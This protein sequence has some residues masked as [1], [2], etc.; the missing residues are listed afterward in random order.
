MIMRR[1][2]GFS[3]IELLVSVALVALLLALLLPGL[4]MARAQARAVKCASN[5]RQLAQAFHMYGGEYRGRAMPLAYTAPKI[6]GDGPPVYWWGTNG[7]AGVD[8]TRGFVWPYLHADLRQNGVFECPDQPWGT[9]RP[10]GAARQVTSTYGYNGYYLCPPHTPGWSAPGPGYIGDR[11]W[12]NIDTLPAPQRLFVF[13]DTLIDLGTGRAENNALLDP[14]YLWFRRRWVANSS[15]TTCFRHAHEA[16][17][18][19]GDGH[20]ERFDPAGGQMTSPEHAIGSVGEDNDPHYVPD[21]R[22]WDD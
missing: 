22:S 2:R 16:N 11:P 20:V 15:P 18:A 4:G 3:L 14:P 6:I 13:A 5:L 9:Y 12:Q 17:I 7:E 8:H 21:W 19:L 1:A 10:Q